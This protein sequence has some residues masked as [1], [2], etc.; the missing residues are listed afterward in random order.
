MKEL[1]QTVEK[2]VKTLQ[3]HINNTQVEENENIEVLLKII[4]EINE[5]ER[6]L[7]ELIDKRNELQELENQLRHVEKTSNAYHVNQYSQSLKVN[8]HKFSSEELR[9]KIEQLSKILIMLEQNK[10]ISIWQ[11]FLLVCRFRKKIREL[12]EEGILLHLL[13]EEEYLTNLVQERRN[14]LEQENFEQRK[15][16]IKRLYL[17]KYIPISRKILSRVIK[18]NINTDNLKEVLSKIE[19]G[20]EQEVTKENKTPILKCTKDNLLQLYSVVLTTVDSVI[21][22]YWSY[23]NEEKK[24]DYIIIDEASQCDI[25]SA[26]PLLYLA[27]NIIVVGDIK[28]LSAITNLDESKLENE[29]RDEYSYTKENFLSSIEKTIHPTSKMLLEH[30]RCDYSIINYCNKFFYDNKLKVYND[31]K[32]GAMVLINDD[33]GKYVEVDNGYQNQREIKCINEQIEQNR[34]GKFVI[35]PFKKQ[36]ELLKPIYGKEKS[37]TIHTFQGKGE[38]EVYFSAVLNETKP[39][40]NHLNSSKNLFTKELINVAVSRAKDKFILV[41]DIAFFKKYDENMRNLIEYIEVYGDKIPDKTVCIFDYLYRQIPMYKQ[42]IPNIDNPYEEKIYHLLVS[43]IHK[44]EEKYKFI[45]KLPLA[46]FVTDKKYL[47]ENEKLKKFILHNSH[48]DFALYTQNINKPVLA[49][50]VDGKTHDLAEQKIRDGMK[51]EILAYMGIPLLR[52]SS[53]VAWDVEDFEKMIEDKLQ[54]N[55][56]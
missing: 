52:I 30:Y 22:N 10:K 41:A 50:E 55:E 16:N 53:K 27:E 46:E 31:T 14:I 45:A 38:K 17:E 5:E 21:S 32:K 19:L 23:F 43:Y 51:E 12:E 11:R 35:T 54:Q 18:Q 34:T 2:Q 37:G 3:S 25:M 28:Q 9:R 1:E 20:K 13:L 8:Y 47:E 42:V 36:A 56:K 39:C 7:N 40:I 4:E 26:L 15:A 29:V 6:K 44:K 48:L 33:K 49:I 24:V